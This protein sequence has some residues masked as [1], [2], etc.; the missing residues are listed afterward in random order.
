MSSVLITEATNSDLWTSR[1]RP[2]F[3][4]VTYIILLMSIPVGI[5]SIFNPQAAQAFTAG[6]KYWLDSIPQDIIQLFGFVMLGYVGAR[7]WE[8]TKG[9]A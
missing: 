9:V 8:K 7:S 5:L 3:L 4:Y 2:S 6:F 1:A